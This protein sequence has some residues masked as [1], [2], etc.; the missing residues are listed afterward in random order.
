MDPRLSRAKISV[1]PRRIRYLLSAV[2][3]LSAVLGDDLLREIVQICL[4]VSDTFKFLSSPRP[5]A[6]TPTRAAAR[7]AFSCPLPPRHIAPPVATP[8]RRASLAFWWRSDL[9]RVDKF[10]LALR[11]DNI[12]GWPWLPFSGATWHNMPL[13]FGSKDRGG[14]LVDQ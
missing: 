5:N 7:R 10:F 13:R 2:G 6:P 12:P 8:S 14:P 3:A 4:Q 9:T 1:A 11:Q